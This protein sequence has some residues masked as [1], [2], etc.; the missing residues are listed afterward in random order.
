MGVLL[1][2]FVSTWRRRFFCGFSFCVSVPYVRTVKS[3]LME[4]VKK[5]DRIHLRLENGRNFDSQ[6]N[7][8]N[9][10]FEW[11]DIK[12]NNHH[13]IRSKTRPIHDVKSSSC[14]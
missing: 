13:E 11:Q 3:V 14:I 5:G 4:D 6:L 1:C 10:N 7:L 8:T 2:E 9:T 12:Y